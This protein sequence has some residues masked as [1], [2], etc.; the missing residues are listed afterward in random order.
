MARDPREKPQSRR[1]RPNRRCASRLFCRATAL[2]LSIQ[3]EPGGSG[4]RRPVRKAGNKRAPRF[5]A[6]CGRGSLRSL[7]TGRL[8]E[9]PRPVGRWREI[10]A[11]NLKAGASVQIVA[12]RPDSSV[13]PLLWIYRYNLSPGAAGTVGL[14]VKPATSAR[15]AFPLP[16]VA[17]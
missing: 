8:D 1:Q 12:V 13:E 14:F 7:I 5:S 15:R 3:P 16:V 6:P 11:K 2:D 9:E 4:N 10:R 17:A